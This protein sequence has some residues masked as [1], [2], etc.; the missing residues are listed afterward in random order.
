MIRHFLWAALVLSVPAVSR[1]QVEVQRQDFFPNGEPGIRLFVRE[2]QLVGSRTGKPILLVHGARVP[3]PASSIF[4]FPDDPPL[5][6]IS[7]DTDLTC[8]SW[9][10]VATAGPP[11][12]KEMNEPANAHAPLVLSDEAVRDISAVVDWIRLRRHVARAAILGLA[13]GGQ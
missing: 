4:P 8:P 1:S 7:P 3:G 13:T 12:P 9:T 2:V 6:R 10:C 5:S 11:R